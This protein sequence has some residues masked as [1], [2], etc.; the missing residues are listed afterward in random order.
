MMNMKM[1]DRITDLEQQLRDVIKM[2]AKQQKEDREC[3]DA[4][5]ERVKEL[6]AKVAILKRWQVF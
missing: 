4:Y 6:E 2:N 1:I 3:I 5:V